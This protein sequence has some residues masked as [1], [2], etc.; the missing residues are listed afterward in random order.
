MRCSTSRCPHTFGHIVYQIGVDGIGVTS[1]T[2]V[3]AL[4]AVFSSLVP[5]LVL[6]RMFCVEKQT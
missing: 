3:R 2:E 4:E 5:S 6:F 1:D